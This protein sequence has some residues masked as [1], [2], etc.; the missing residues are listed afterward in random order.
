M[1]RRYIGKIMIFTRQKGE[2]TAA[3]STG[4]MNICYQIIFDSNYVF[5]RIDKLKM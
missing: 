3:C 4:N 1:K 2:P 5:N